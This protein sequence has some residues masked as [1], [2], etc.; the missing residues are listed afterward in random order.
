[1]RVVWLFQDF[2]LDE[3]GSAKQ[4]NEAEVIRYTYIS[5]YFIIVVVG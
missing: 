3:V 4:R 5:K 1:M 2:V